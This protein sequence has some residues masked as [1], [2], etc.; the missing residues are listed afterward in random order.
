MNGLSGPVPQGPSLVKGLSGPY[1]D[2]I[3]RQ[4][5]RI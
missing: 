5:Y 3:P 2:G 1:A 4:G